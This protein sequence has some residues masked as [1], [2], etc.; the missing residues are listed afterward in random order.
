MKMES[1]RAD[2]ATILFPAEE[3]HAAER[4][5]GAMERAARLLDGHWGLRPPRGL[6]VCVMT[7]WLGSTLACAPVAV[8]PWL[9]LTL[10]LWGPR[11]RRTWPL[12]GG[13][14]MRMG[15]R[16]VIC[17]KPPRLIATAD[18]SIGARIF[19][20]QPD[21]ERKVESIVCHELT[22]A[23]TVHLRLPSWLGEGLA[24]VMT[25]RF[26]G[27][28]TVRPETVGTLALAPMATNSRHY[29]KV[30]TGN[31]DALVALY[32]AGYWRVRTLEETRPELFPRLLG[33]GSPPRDGDWL[34]LIARALDMNRKD[35]PRWLDDQV[36]D[37]FARDGGAVNSPS[38]PSG[39]ARTPV[40]SW[41]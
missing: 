15:W 27:G 7:S 19:L 17:V 14:A 24:M 6:H 23:C 34:A 18:P 40:R 16:P 37:R 1:L 22:H 38:A 39:S 30:A 9:A 12:A 29:P 28:P 41:A 2:G 5:G 13:W 11:V 4:I 35:F 33:R 8:R 26:T 20:R 31:A 32:V 21:L 25:D 36:A 10:P 3:R